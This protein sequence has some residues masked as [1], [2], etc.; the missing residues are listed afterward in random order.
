MVDRTTREAWRAEAQEFEAGFWSRAELEADPRVESEAILDRWGY[1]LDAFAGEMVLDVGC[2]PTRR[3]AALRGAVLEAIEPLADV[4]RALPGY[5]LRDYAVVYQAAI[6]DELPALRGRYGMIFA[7][8]SLDH[9][10]DLAA[11]LRNLRSY[12]SDGGRAMISMDCDK[13]VEEDRTHP[14]CVRGEDLRAALVAAGFRV[15]REETGDC[16]A[17]RFDGVVD[18]LSWGGGLAYHFWLAVG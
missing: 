12:L 5:V 16:R 3:L 13:W 2:G 1:G 17:A 11:A 15:L 9:C 14:I 18:S 4:Y 7:I 6:E 10:F 8:N